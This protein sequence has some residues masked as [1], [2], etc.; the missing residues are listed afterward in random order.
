[1]YVPSL[2]IDEISS[3]I[4]L[5][6]C[7]VYCEIHIA[8]DYNVNRESAM[9][10]LVEKYIMKIVR[11]TWLRKIVFYTLGENKEKRMIM[12]VVVG[13]TD[14]PKPINMEQEKGDAQT[15]KCVRD[16]SFGLEL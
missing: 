12:V 16:I 9:V 1:M 11:G 4:F 7:I 13:Y 8:L 2:I 10:T 6:V 15:I 14:A 5:A 3:F